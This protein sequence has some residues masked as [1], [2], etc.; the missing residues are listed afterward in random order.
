MRKT[1]ATSIL[2]WSWASLSW[3][4]PLDLNQAKEIEL[5]ALQGVGPALTQALMHERQKMPFKDW[6]DATRR[7]KGLGPH[8][9]QSLS[10]QGVRV[11]GRAYSAPAAASR[12]AG[13]SGAQPAAAPP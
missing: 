7:V 3:A 4:Q 10:D 2:V 6:E 5:D 11:H 9:A 8:K 12:P 1:V 13:G